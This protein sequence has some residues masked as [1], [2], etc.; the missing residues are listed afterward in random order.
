MIQLALLPNDYD[1]RESVEVSLENCVVAK[2]IQ[3]QMGNCPLSILTKPINIVS[4]EWGLDPKRTA[5]F[6]TI[7][8]IL[9][10][11]IVNN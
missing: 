5:G 9:A 10:Y 6:N 2:T 7:K 1:K 3:L 8:R 4:K 11:S